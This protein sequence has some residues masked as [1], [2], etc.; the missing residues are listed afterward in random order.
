M[1]SLSPKRGT[2]LVKNDNGFVCANCGKQVEK[3]GITSRNHC[4]Y[5]LHSLH[6]DI[7]PG[8]RANTCKG[9]LVPIAIE[10]NPKKGYVIVFRCQKCGSIVKNKSAPDD[11]F[12]KL[13]EI[14]KFNATG[15]KS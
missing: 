3:L 2:T 11:D 5:C 8:D 6:V 13:L 1:L 4:P 10:N 15:R 7:I 12:D 14:S 9:L